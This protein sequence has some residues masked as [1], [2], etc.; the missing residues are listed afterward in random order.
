[1]TEFAHVSLRVKKQE[2]FRTL[3]ELVDLLNDLTFAINVFGDLSK[4]LQT[5]NMSLP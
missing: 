2:Y 3:L 1:M 5:A 4:A